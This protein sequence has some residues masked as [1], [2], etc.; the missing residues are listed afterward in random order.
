MVGVTAI[1]V[2]CR[3]G[4]VNDLGEIE[5]LW[6]DGVVI[7]FDLFGPGL[8]ARMSDPLGTCEACGDLL[9]DAEARGE[10]RLPS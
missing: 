5:G 4:H 10:W 6:P 3:C 2:E 9:A 1:V 7:P 8:R